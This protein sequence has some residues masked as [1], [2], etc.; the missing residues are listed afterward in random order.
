MSFN[1]SKISALQG[2]TGATGAAGADGADGADGLTGDGLGD[3]IT[4]GTPAD[5]YIG[6]WTAD[7][8]MEG[9][10]ALVF[11]AGTSS[12]IINTSDIG[13]RTQTTNG[14]GVIYGGTDMN[15]GIL[16][17]K[18]RDD[19]SDVVDHHSYGSHRFYT[20]GHI[21]SQSNRM[22]ITSGGLVGIGTDSP[23]ARI[24][25]LGSDPY[26][27]MFRNTQG[28]IRL[29][30]DASLNQIVSRG[31]ADSGYRNL[32]IRAAA[33]GSGMVLTT[34]GSLGIGGTP[35][36]PLHVISSAS[37]IR[38]QST[39]NSN[40]IIDIR[41]DGTGDSMV[42][43]NLAGIVPFSIGVDNS[44]GDRFKISGHYNLGSTDRL[45]INSGGDCSWYNAA[46]SAVKMTWDA[47]NE[48][49][50]IGTAVPTSVLHCSSTSSTITCQS[51]GDS[52]SI[53]DIRADGTGDSKI[54]F[55][56]AG[57]TP[58]AIGVDNS[59]GDKF[60]ISGHYNLG[61]NDRLTVT[62]AGLIGLGTAAP[63]N[64]LSLTP[65]TQYTQA[66][67]FS[68][69]T[70]TV[71]GGYIGDGGVS[72]NLWITAGG[73]VTATTGS[74]DGFTARCNESA[75]NGKVAAIRVGNSAGTIGFY[76]ATGLTNG[77]TFTLDGG[78]ETGLAMSI[79]SGGRVTV[80]KSSNS[81]VTDLVDASTVAIDFDDANNFKLLTTSGIGA[82]REL[83]TPSN[84][85]AGQSGCIVIT[86][87]AA[88]RLLT[89][90]SA[91]HFEGGTDPVL[92]ADSGGVDTLAYYCPTDAIVQAVLLKD[93]K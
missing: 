56:L 84:I 20:G 19:A 85:T 14:G 11:D 77:S 90:T 59:D 25:V 82:T 6:V 35:S 80:A 70:T 29:Q 75:G 67:K 89:Y 74:V 81:V 87:D 22:T 83:G 1:S 76:T 63:T 64:L 39:G 69:G 54:F 51:T 21:Q 27:G 61:T 37:T 24:D 41:A 3:V 79:N 65:A 7:N 42:N 73:E 34:T 91:W 4:V 40:S 28:G 30:T 46:G 16:F 9:T 93:L 72:E 8:A 23:L 66:L 60:K 55:D 57:A 36:A 47:T 31:A 17:R 32:E 43:F 92:T 18:G 58:F 49:L 10:S 52:D 48:R 5:S 53:V 15:H 50:G 88:S 71:S 38:C 45:S 13:L 62:S 44:D 12:G 78:S 68:V 26:L 2:S 86:S 33:S